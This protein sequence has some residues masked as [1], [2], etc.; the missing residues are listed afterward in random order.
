MEKRVRKTA[1]PQEVI[2]L[3]LKIREIMTKNGFKTRDIAYESDMDVENFRKYLNGRQEMKVS[4]MLKI[5]NALNV[6][7]GELFDKDL[8]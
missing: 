1:I 3:G 6:S 7:V 8:K 4:T 2:D 5:A